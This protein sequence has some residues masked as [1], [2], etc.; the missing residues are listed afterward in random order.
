MKK[1]RWI[2]VAFLLGLLAGVLLFSLK[3]AG[4]VAVVKIEG[5]IYDPDPVLE[6]LEELRKSKRV[7]AVVLRIDSPGG[8]VGASQE[9][10]DAVLQLTATK[11]V[12]AS[13]GAVAASGGYY[14]ALPAHKILASPGTITGSIGVR[15]E[16]LNVEDLLHWAKVRAETLKSGKWKDIGSSTRPMQPEEKEFLAAVLKKMHEQFKTAVVQGRHLDPKVVD[17]LAEG[18]VFTGEEAVQ[19]GLIDELGSLQAAIKVAANLAGIKGEPDV[20]YPAPDYRTFIER[21]L[22]RAVQHLV[23]LVAVPRVEFLY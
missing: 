20:Y 16:Y 4:N 14:V 15:M 21:V 3:P 1:K 11:Q 5:G 7:L 8:S 13:L 17:S 2:F 6:E 10:H 23:G 9:I 12:V 18:Q 19:N 22:G